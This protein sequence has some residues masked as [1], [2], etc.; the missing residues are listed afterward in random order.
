MKQQLL[1]QDASE[2]TFILILEEGDEAFLGH[3]GLRSAGGHSRRIGDGDRRLQQR[4][5]GLLPCRKQ[6]LQEDPRS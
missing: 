4:D 2:R 6:R 5:G 3:F 1:A